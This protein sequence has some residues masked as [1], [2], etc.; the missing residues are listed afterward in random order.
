MN[1]TKEVTVLHLNLNSS[2]SEPTDRRLAAEMPS[3]IAPSALTGFADASSYDQHRPSYPLE[4][5]DSLLNHLQIKNVTGAVV[6]DLGAG[7]GKFTALLEARPENYEILAVEPHE[8]MR[9][10][11][12]SKRLKNVSVMTGVATRMS[13][14][15]QT[16]DAVIASQVALPLSMTL[17]QSPA[18]SWCLCRP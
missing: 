1:E 18:E 11:L 4:A 12:E 14:D 7:T 3:T 2:Y 13:L 16:V 8:A 17:I 10:E 6:V 9:K 15:A 5:V